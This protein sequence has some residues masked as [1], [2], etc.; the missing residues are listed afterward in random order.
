MNLDVA[1]TKA[2]IEYDNLQQ[3]PRE[4]QLNAKY[5]LADLQP[6]EITRLYISQEY[7]G[8]L[9]DFS[10]FP[11]LVEFSC[12]KELPFEYFRDQNMTEIKKLRIA[13]NCHQ[14]RLSINAPALHEIVIYPSSGPGRDLFNTSNKEIIFDGAPLLEAVCIRRNCVFDVSSIRSLRKLRRL[15]IFD[16]IVPENV[17]HDELESLDDLCISDCEL[18][19]IDFL[20][21]GCNLQHLD[22]NRNYIRVFDRVASFPRLKRLIIYENPIQNEVFLRQLGINE[23]IINHRD[24]ILAEYP[25]IMKTCRYIAYRQLLSIRTDCSKYYPRHQDYIRNASDEDLFLLYLRSAIAFEY[26][27]IEWKRI[28]YKIADDSFIDSY[29]ESAVQEYPFLDAEWLKQRIGV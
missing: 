14:D 7:E 13:V 25:R 5:G 16:G 23:L 8:V 29:I 3:A 1:I 4:A 27:S 9:P 18:T 24:K 17:I 2:K 15:T 20:K 21:V 26:R 10:L 22:L 28:R 11:C 12:S 6:D 19:N